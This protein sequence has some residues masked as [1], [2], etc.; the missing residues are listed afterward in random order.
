MSEMTMSLQGVGKG[1]KEEISFQPFSRTSQEQH[2][3]DVLRPSVPQSGSGSRK[4]PVAD[5]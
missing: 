5:G 3:R 1:M 4:S 2:R